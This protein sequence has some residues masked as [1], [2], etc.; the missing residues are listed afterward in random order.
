MRETVVFGDYAISD[1]YDVIDVEPQMAGRVNNTMQVSG[2]DGVVLTGSTLDATNIAVTIMLSD[3]GMDERRDA[4]RELAYMI[5]SRGAQRL[6]LGRDGGL[7]YMAAPDGKNPI[8]S[9]VRSGKV[10]INFTA[11]SPVLYGER[12]RV[13]VSDGTP[14][15]VIVGGTYGTMPTIRGTVAGEL[16]TGYVCAVRLDNQDTLALEVGDVGQVGVDVD[17]EKRVA[18]VSG[19]IALP[20]LES[21]WLV[22]EP[23]AHTLDMPVGTGSVTV[24]WY[25]RWV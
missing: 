3:M 14:V 5:R 23:G 7:W 15:D 21:D 25:E 22:M 20:T 2:M 18:K 9:N 16:S 8:S 19:A 1:H 6:M 24:E 12:R 10:V 17:C 11:H 4:I 13:T